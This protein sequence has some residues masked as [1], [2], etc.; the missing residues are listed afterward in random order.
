MALVADV[1]AGPPTIVAAA[2][3]EVA[4]LSTVLTP[5]GSS[6]VALEADVVAG[7]PPVVVAVALDADFV[8]GPHPLRE[9]RRGTGG[10]RCHRPSCHCRHRR[11]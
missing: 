8:G 10:R 6:A 1:V 4:A 9:R 3:L 7:P 2:A 5:S 11:P